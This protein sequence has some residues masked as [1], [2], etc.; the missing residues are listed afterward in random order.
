MKPTQTRI[1]VSP[2]TQV[3][4]ILKR[5]VVTFFS[6]FA[7]LPQLHADVV[8]SGSIDLAIPWTDDGIYLNLVTGVSDPDPTK[9]PGWDVQIHDRFSLAFNAPGPVPSGLGSRVDGAAGVNNLAGLEMGPAVFP[10]RDGLAT[11]AGARAI[12]LN[13]DLNYVGISFRNESTD[14]QHFGWIRL[15]LGDRYGGSNGEPRTI[16]EYAYDSTADTPITI[17]DGGTSMDPC[18]EGSASAL[19]FDYN[20]LSFPG[21]NCIN[22]AVGA[23]GERLL[24]TET[25][26]VDWRSPAYTL[27]ESARWRAPSGPQLTAKIENANQPGSSNPK[28][29]VRELAVENVALEMDQIA[30]EFRGSTPSLRMDN[31]EIDFAR[32]TPPNTLVGPEPLALSATTG[33]NVIS[34]LYGRPGVFHVRVEPGASL[35]FFQNG[36]DLVGLPDSER[37]LFNDPGSKFLVDGGTLRV[38]HTI[39]KASLEA[40][41]FLV[42]GGGTLEVA[43][44]GNLGSIYLADGDLTLE[45]STLLLTTN[46]GLFTKAEDVSGGV[47]DAG[48]SG[49]NAVINLQAGAEADIQG[50]FSVSG[51]TTVSIAPVGA[52]FT[53]KLM[54]LADSG[55]TLRIRSLEY[56]TQTGG[57][58]FTSDP[59]VLNGGTV[60][61]L[62]GG[63]FIAVGDTVLFGDGTF[64]IAG[65]DGQL[66]VSSVFDVGSDARL[67]NDYA[68]TVNSGGLLNVG[69]RIERSDPDSGFNPTLTVNENATLSIKTRLEM[70]ESDL[71]LLGL[72]RTAL[73]LFPSSGTFEFISSGGGDLEIESLAELSLELGEGS[74]KV[75]QIGEKFLLFDYREGGTRFGTF[76]NLPEGA[77]IPLGLNTYRIHYSDP[78][79]DADDPS[80][81]TLTV[82]D[83]P[84]LP[85]DGFPSESVKI[86]TAQVLA[87]HPELLTD[88]PL[89]ITSV[90][91]TTPNGAS[92]VMRGDLIFYD[93]K[94]FLGADRFSYTV[95]NAAGQSAEG[96]VTV[97]IADNPGLSL[98]I[99]GIELPADGTAVIRAAGIP[100]RTYRVQV[101]DGGAPFNWM[102]IPGDLVADPLGK[103]VYID[104]GPLPPIRFYRLL[105]R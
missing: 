97:S 67:I 68:I 49:K 101:S 40:G 99:V 14:T 54:E 25:N 43:K 60:E 57:R 38:D 76:N 94:G 6:V 32:W 35:N 105:Q 24:F 75:L 34:G 93:P 63:H 85:V 96:F 83:V 77:L 19:I 82:V 39:L 37:L 31:G 71:Y 33:S 65:S 53:C 52:T 70:E 50:L 4:S 81:I 56:P 42:T 30:M 102:S 98:N 48:L 1:P 88:P 79:Y 8:E 104:P 74:D 46:S 87:N 5:S 72:S 89:T 95:E 58:F 78:D 55:T 90:L 9:V 22:L 73:D 36:E 84:I 62:E 2:P 7:S 41:Q 17:P 28:L 44:L 64:H 3:G 18:L 103:V 23:D 66:F 47:S 91:S 12:L 80:V 69:P 15:L 26:N 100:G 21:F 27:W 20:S 61:V 51:D 86:E 13:S 92:V 29:V 16:V 59:I 10:L 11:E 45:D